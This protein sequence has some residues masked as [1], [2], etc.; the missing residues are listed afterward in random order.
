LVRWRGVQASPG[1]DCQQEAP[2][3]AITSQFVSPKRCLIAFCLR[4]RFEAFRLSVDSRAEEE[5]QNPRVFIR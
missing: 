4:H 1:I 2:R 5:G 3:S